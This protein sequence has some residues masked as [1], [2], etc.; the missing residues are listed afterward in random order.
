[1]AIR[2]PFRFDI[3]I[4]CLAIASG[5]PSYF[6]SHLLAAGAVPATAMHPKAVTLEL[7]CHDGADSGTFK[8]SHATVLKADTWAAAFRSVADAN[9]YSAVPRARATS[10]G[11]SAAATG[12][13]A[14]GR[15]GGYRHGHR[16]ARRRIGLAAN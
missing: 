2:K 10:P 3:L 16:R 12:R 9:G 4:L 7:V 8:P 14:G 5:G 11:Q 15:R 1:M 6:F 13:R